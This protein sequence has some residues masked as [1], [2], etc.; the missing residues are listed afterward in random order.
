MKRKSYTTFAAIHLGS[1]LISMQIT[2]YSGIDKYKVVECCSKRVRLGEETFKNKIIPFSLVNEIC[3]ILQGFKALMEEY[4]V[5]E[6]KMQATTAV[7]EARNQIDRKSV[8]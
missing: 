1:E 3:E 6:Y 5:E 8:V 7:R 4:G 2:E